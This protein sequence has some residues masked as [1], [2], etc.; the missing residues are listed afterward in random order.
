M[1]S[2]MPGVQFQGTLRL[3]NQ[4]GA[5][6]FRGF[7]GTTE[8]MM[9]TELEL[10][11]DDAHSQQTSRQQLFNLLESISHI[12]MLEERYGEYE[13]PDQDLFMHIYLTVFNDT[14][15]EMDLDGDVPDSMRDRVDALLLRIPA[16]VKR[17]KGG[18]EPYLAIA[19]ILA[20]HLSWRIFDCHLGVYLD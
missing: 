4:P 20:E 6:H 5:T 8:N 19:R 16:G 1:F 13:V 2:N 14:G 12:R 3:A 17:G 15:E 11:S 7:L 18:V 10:R 9:S